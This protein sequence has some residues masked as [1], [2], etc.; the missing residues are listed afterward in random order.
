MRNYLKQLS[1][2]ALVR[3]FSGECGIVVELEYRRDHHYMER[4]LWALVLIENK[5]VWIRA[6]DL[7]ES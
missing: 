3:T 5:N 4:D 1:D 6:N 7:C 2:G